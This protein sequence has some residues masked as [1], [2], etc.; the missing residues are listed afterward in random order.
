MGE[1]L[2][3]IL[4]TV[5]A[6]LQDAL[7]APQPSETP[8]RPTRSVEVVEEE[9]RP[10]SSRTLQLFID[11]KRLDRAARGYGRGGNGSPR[12]VS[13]RF[14][15]LEGPKWCSTWPFGVKS[16]VEECGN[17][18][19]ERPRSIRAHPSPTPQRLPSISMSEPAISG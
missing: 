14:G 3:Q 5:P 6:V 12:A 16:V 1:D 4:A 9:H 10:S 17:H 2:I 8:P 18:A 19:G 7:G 11:V 13:G 15:G